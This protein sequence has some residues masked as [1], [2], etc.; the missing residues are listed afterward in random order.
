MNLLGTS[1]A[2]QFR[3]DTIN[4]IVLDLLPLIILELLLR[5]ERLILPLLASVAQVSVE[6]QHVENLSG[7]LR[8]YLS[9]SWILFILVIVSDS[10]D[11]LDDGKLT[12]RR[13]SEHDHFGRVPS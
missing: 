4:T 1:T 6:H 9:K 2:V 7:K 8:H 13:S 5:K 3:R 10:P 11:T 12:L